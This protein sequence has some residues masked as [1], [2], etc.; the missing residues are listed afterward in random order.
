LVEFLKTELPAYFF[1]ANTIELIAGQDIIPDQYILVMESGGIEGHGHKFNIYTVQILTR[2]IDAP[3]ARK[4]SYDIYSKI[5]NRI[6]LIL[7]TAIIGAESFNEI[8]TSQI[9]A[10]QSP[11]PLGKN[12]E[13]LFEFTNNYQIYFDAEVNK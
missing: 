4:M 11:Y 13:G 1:Y 6:G 3:I 12:S 5:D 8:Q 9:S 10:I 2:S 7:P